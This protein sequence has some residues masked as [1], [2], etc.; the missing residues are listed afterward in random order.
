MQDLLI[1]LFLISLNCYTAVRCD[2]SVMSHPLHTWNLLSAAGAALSIWIVIS[3]FAQ[4]L[5]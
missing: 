4:M 5:T 2:P 1:G 3:G